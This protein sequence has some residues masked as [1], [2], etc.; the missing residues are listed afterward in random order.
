MIEFYRIDKTHPGVMMYECE[1][2]GT[3]TTNT[4]THIDWHNKLIKQLRY[5]VPTEKIIEDGSKI[6]WT[7]QELIDQGIIT[8]RR[9]LRKEP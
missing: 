4:Q 6:T 8:S 1:D 2:C 3:I 9:I 5:F 7:L